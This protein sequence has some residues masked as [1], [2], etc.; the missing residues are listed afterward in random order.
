VLLLPLR[1]YDF[2]IAIDI[3]SDRVKETETRPQISGPANKTHPNF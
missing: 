2:R 1:R 3:A